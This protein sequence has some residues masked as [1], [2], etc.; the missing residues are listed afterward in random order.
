MTLQKPRPAV[1]S[2]R[3]AEVARNTTD[4][5]VDQQLLSESAGG[6]STTDVSLPYVPLLDVPLRGARP[7]GSIGEV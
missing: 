2:L 3:E 7:A 4:V 5:D 1:P 6:S